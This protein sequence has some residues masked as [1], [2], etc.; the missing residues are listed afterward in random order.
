ME[1][2]ITGFILDLILGDPQGYPHP[3]RYIGSLISLVEKKLYRENKK[4]HQLIAGVFLVLLVVGITYLLTYCIIRL[5]YYIHP[6]AGFV[7][8]VILAYTVLATKCLDA[9]ARK[10]YDKLVAKDLEGGR[11]AL[12]FIVSRDTAD[13]SEAELVRGTVETVAENI[14]DG[15][16]APLFYLF[17]GGV[18][19]AMAYKAINTLDSMVGYRNDRYEYFGKTAAYLDD[20]V[21][22]IPARLSV[23]LISIAAIIK[24]KGGIKAFKIAVRDGKNHK[25]PNSGYPEAAVAGALGIQLGGT[26]KYFGKEIYKPTIGNLKE[27]LVKE[28]I[29]ATIKLMYL[30]SITGIILFS[31]INFLLG[32]L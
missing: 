27:P 12:S 30:A 4:I 9:E 17:V 14:S 7:A 15:I 8:S 5:A 20:L 25:S 28:H 21:N 16:I 1:I 31:V 29:T 26:N 24:G 13:L 23:L 18:P 3:V 2:I 10:V 19:I 22:Y 6:A 32:V 11:R